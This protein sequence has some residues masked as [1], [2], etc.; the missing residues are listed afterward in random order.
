[1]KIISTLNEASFYEI[2]VGL[3][4][5]TVRSTVQ[6]LRFFDFLVSRWPRVGFL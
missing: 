1:M 2:E 5:F 6:R 4:N 3:M